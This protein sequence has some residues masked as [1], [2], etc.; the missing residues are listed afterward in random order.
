MGS[1]EKQLLQSQSSGPGWLFC[2]RAPSE[3][4]RDP[5]PDKF[6][7]IRTRSQ[8]ITRITIAAVCGMISTVLAPEQDTT[9][10]T[11]WMLKK[12]KNATTG[13]ND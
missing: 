3:P 5:K 13:A 10:E 9:R 1:T 2:Y 8:A 7:E 6:D 12:K 11:F 4:P